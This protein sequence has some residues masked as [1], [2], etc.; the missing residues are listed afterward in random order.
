M[1]AG[2]ANLQ[3]DAADDTGVT[4]VTGIGADA[5]VQV[6][7]AAGAADVPADGA[8]VRQLS[9]P[10]RGLMVGFVVL[11]ALGTN[12][13][14]VLSTHTD[15][16]FAWTIRPPLTA[17]F[18]G[19]GYAA[20]L[21]LV[22][23]GLRARA[24][25]EARIAVVTVAVF[26][27]LTLLATVLHRDRF[28]F[29]ADGAIAR[30]AAWFWLGIYIVVPIAL[31]VLT[32]LQQRQPGVDPPRRHPLPAWLAGA[33]AVQGLIM[34][35][36]GAALYAVPSTAR[37]LWPWTLTPLTARAVAAW[38]IAFG[39]AAVLT[40]V[41]RDL[42]RLAAGAVAYTVFGVLQLV[43]VLRYGDVARWDSPA[44]IGYLVVLISV[45]P[46]GAAGCWLVAARARRRRAAGA[47][48]AGATPAR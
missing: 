37:S 34:L 33:F 19:A 1:P 28:H 14:Y 4:T 22:L 36:V 41:E 11:T 6:D 9:R 13:L 29:S 35:A 23:L 43:A 38:L 16:Y 20:G 15:A 5:D 21:V 44:G 8:P 26:S 45:V 27:T 42:D 17:A 3:E 32:V 47:T 7:G 46:V 2:T 24:W 10:T 31:V 30:F 40:L 39:V 12:Q 48:P 18:L 25:A